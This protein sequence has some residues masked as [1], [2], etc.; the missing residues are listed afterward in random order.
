M[1][2]NHGFC[3]YSGLC[4]G[5][6]YSVEERSLLKTVDDYKRLHRRPFPTWREILAIFY[7]LGYRLVAR[8]KKLPS[9]DQIAQEVR[10]RK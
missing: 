1:S 6:D 4:S 9:P 8:R 2:L 10:N 7:S 5:D 3:W